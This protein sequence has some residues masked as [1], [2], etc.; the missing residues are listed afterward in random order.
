[1]HGR[2][3]ESDLNSLLASGDTASARAMRDAGGAIGTALA[4]VVAALQLE[5]IVVGGPREIPM[6]HLVTGVRTRVES[7]VHPQVLQ[8]LSIRTAT[9][10][11]F[12]PLMGAMQIA[13]RIARA[14][15]RHA[16]Q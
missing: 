9:H 2:L 8:H 14:H 10:G 6:E 1:V 15:V 12:A 3:I 13:E 7:L 11:P 5:D 16:P 4:P